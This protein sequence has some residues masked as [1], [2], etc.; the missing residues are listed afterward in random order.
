[1]VCAYLTIYARVRMGAPTGAPVPGSV[2]TSDTQ[3]H[4]F[5]HFTGFTT[6][7]STTPIWPTLPHTFHHFASHHLAPPLCW[8]N[9]LPVHCIAS[10]PPCPLTAPERLPTLLA[11]DEEEVIFHVTHDAL[12]VSA[13]QDTD[14]DPK[15]LI[16]VLKC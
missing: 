12:I 14:S 7:L 1:M 15:S 2:L 3:C 11:D 5:Q 10:S 16:E 8:H 6:C 4:C 9:N 13:I